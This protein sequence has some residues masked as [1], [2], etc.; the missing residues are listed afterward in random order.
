ME[1]RSLMQVDRCISPAMRPLRN[2]GVRKFLEIGS[3]QAS[4]MQRSHAAGHANNEHRPTTQL[5]EYIDR[6]GRLKDSDEQ[7]K[8]S[9]IWLPMP[10]RSYRSIW[11]RDI[12]TSQSCRSMKFLFVGLTGVVGFLTSILSSIFSQGIPSFNNGG[13]CTA[14]QINPPLL[15]TAG[16]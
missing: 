13:A 3:G 14:S 4:C 12:G 1:E 16:R 9:E 10:H 5:Y 8:M 11:L 7:R 6:D 2:G 15:G